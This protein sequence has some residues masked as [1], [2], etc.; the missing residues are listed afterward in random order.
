[1][2]SHLSH[3]AQLYAMNMTI[4]ILAQTREHSS[5]R[6]MFNG[7]YRAFQRE[8]LV[9]WGGIFLAMGLSGYLCGYVLSAII[10]H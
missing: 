3:R 9:L 5:M 1:M 7:F 2:N 10:P 6:S 8:G 4:Q